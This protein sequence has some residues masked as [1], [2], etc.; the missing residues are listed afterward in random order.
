MLQIAQG[1][2]WMV[3]RSMLMGIRE[4][5]DD[6]Q[7]G[8]ARAKAAEE[9]AKAKETANDETANATATMPLHPPQECVGGTTDKENIPPRVGKTRRRKPPLLVVRGRRWSPSIYRNARL[10]G[11]ETDRAWAEAF[12]Q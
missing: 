10:A 3:F 5:Y 2:A 9:R 11:L 7:E 12:V 1:Q 8:L 4:D 6:E